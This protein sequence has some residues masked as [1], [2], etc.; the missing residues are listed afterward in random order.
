MT[1]CLLKPLH[2]YCELAYFLLLCIGKRPNLPNLLSFPGK[3]NINIH[4][5][6]GTKY[7]KFG[8]LLLNDETGAEINTIALKYGKDA[9]LINL[10]ILRRSI[11]GRGNPLSWDTLIDLCCKLDYILLLVTLK[12]H[13]SGSCCFFSKSFCWTVHLEK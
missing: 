10:E 6:I 5:Q 12:M 3:V 9:E 7:P 4:R 11:E 13:F 2:I 1:A 8:I